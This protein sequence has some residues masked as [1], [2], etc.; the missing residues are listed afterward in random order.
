MC[1]SAP[2]APDVP[3]IPE[4]QAAKLPDNGSTAPRADETAR[5]RR[6]LMATILTSPGGA[7]GT[8][9]TTSLGVTGG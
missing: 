9:S 3:T 1:I 2:K 4:R 8:P 6:A 5:R 7:L